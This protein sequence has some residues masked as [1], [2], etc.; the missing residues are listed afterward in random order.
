M[1]FCKWER[2]TDDGE[3]YY[4]VLPGG[5]IDSE[6]FVNEGGIRLAMY[7][8]LMCLLKFVQIII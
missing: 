5:K 2:T 3:N 6:L 1:R 7:I 4:C 8:N